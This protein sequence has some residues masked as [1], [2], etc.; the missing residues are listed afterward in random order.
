MEI[1]LEPGFRLRFEPC[2]SMVHI[3]RYDDMLGEMRLSIH[4]IS[5]LSHIACQHTIRYQL[6]I[7]NVTLP[8]VGV[9]IL[10]TLRYKNL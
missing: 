8:A 7:S 4:A 3:K 1:N 5:I 2:T 6:L 10:V 9:N